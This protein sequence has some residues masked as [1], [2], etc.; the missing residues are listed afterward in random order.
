MTAP[1]RRLYLRYLMELNELPWDS[2]GTTRTC[3][4][5]KRVEEL[6]ST[7]DDSAL[8]AGCLLQC[9]I[10]LPVH[11]RRSKPTRQGNPKAPLVDQIDDL[12]LHWEH[13]NPVT[14]WR[15]QASLWG[16]NGDREVAKEWGRRMKEAERIEEER[17]ATKPAPRE[18]TL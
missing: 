8:R 13:Y 17:K 6:R 14:F 12:A 15:I 9:L 2:D 3:Y 16:K 11:W 4:L 10:D 5:I 1:P 7:V 18:R